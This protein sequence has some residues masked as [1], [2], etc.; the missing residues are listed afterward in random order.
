V[1]ERDCPVDFAQVVE[2]HAT[3]CLA[4]GLRVHADSMTRVPAAYGPQLTSY[5]SGRASSRDR[6]AAIE[7][8]AEAR[9]QFDAATAAGEVWVLPTVN[10]AAPARSTTG[11]SS[12]QRFATFAG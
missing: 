11:D 8:Q 2:L 3:L 7:A 12:L 4:E 10:G 9:K 5:L 6:D 1:V